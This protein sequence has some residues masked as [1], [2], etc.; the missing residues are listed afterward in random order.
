MR[1][2]APAI[3]EKTLDNSEK[4]VPGQHNRQIYQSKYRDAILDQEM[5]LRIV[6]EETALERIVITLYKTSKLRKYQ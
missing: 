5:L 3:A 2:I 6:V 1:D 4:I